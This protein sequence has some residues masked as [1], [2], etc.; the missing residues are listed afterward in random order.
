MKLIYNI[1]NLNNIWG[2]KMGK[3]NLL[4]ITIE[5]KRLLLRPISYDYVDKIFKEFTSE[6]TQYM[7]PKPAENIEETKDFIK[8]SLE[9]LIEGTNLQLVIVNKENNEFVGCIGLHNINTIEPELG[10]WVKKSSHNNGYGLEAMIGLINWTHKN[11]KFDHL[12]YPVDKRNKASRRLP[13][14]NNGKIMKEYKKI[15]S[16]GNDLDEYEYWIY[17]KTNN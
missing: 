13:E 4:D 9:G 5:T 11:I 6:I 1:R 16:G 17:P 8:K 10:I 2:I 14:N 3:M 12:K 15:G 7:Y